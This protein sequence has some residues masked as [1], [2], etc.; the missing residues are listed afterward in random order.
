[1][2]DRLAPW[3]LDRLEF[4]WNHYWAQPLR[5]RV[6]VPKG[7]K[8]D[9]LRR[10]ERLLDRNRRWLNGGPSSSLEQLHGELTSQ[11]VVVGGWLADEPDYV[12]DALELLGGPKVLTMGIWNFLRPD[13]RNL[14]ALFT[15]ALGMDEGIEEVNRQRR[16]QKAKL[17]RAWEQDLK[18]HIEQIVFLSSNSNDA[19]SAAL[20]SARDAMAAAEDRLSS[21]L[22]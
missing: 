4:T 11:L 14:H 10:Y 21:D 9:T 3:H 1:M 6:F 22:S 20:E 13:C 17:I 12:P 16:Q 18:A 5:F 19:L 7:S 8:A 2:N 15:T